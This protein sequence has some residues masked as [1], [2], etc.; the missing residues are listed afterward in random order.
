M[1][2]VSAR[3]T[4]DPSAERYA[5]LIWV[6]LK[7]TRIVGVIP[8]NRLLMFMRL[9]EQRFEREELERAATVGD[10]LVGDPEVASL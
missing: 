8:E 4:N 9:A 6:G 10:A 5:G 2:L 7:F 3:F 1:E